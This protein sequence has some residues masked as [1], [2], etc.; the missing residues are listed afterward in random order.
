VARKTPQNGELWRCL[1]GQTLY[2][3]PIDG[4]NS[5]VGDAHAGDLFLVVEAKLAFDKEFYVLSHL[6]LA[7]ASNTGIEHVE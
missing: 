7:Y 6:G 4:E 1:V 3:T 5:L 2:A